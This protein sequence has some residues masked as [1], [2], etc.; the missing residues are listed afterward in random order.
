VDLVISL[1]IRSSRMFAVAD[2]YK[3]WYDLDDYEVLRELG[4]V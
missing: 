3:H 2:A 4:G 1:N